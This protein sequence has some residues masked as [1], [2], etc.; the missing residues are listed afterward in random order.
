M[1]SECRSGSCVGRCENETARECEN[2]G[3]C[4]GGVC[5][6]HCQ[7][8]CCETAN[9]TGG[10]ICRI[11]AV[12]S[13]TVWACGPANLGAK[14][15]A[16]TCGSNPE[17]KNENCV[18]ASLTGNKR[19]TPPCC[20]TADCRAFGAAFANTVCAYGQSGGDRIKWCLPPVLNLGFCEGGDAGC[21]KN[22][23]CDGGAC[24]GGLGQSC[25]ATTD[26]VSRYCDG[27]LPRKCRAAC[28]TDADC[29]SNE[30][31]QPSPVGEPVLRCVPKP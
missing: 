21:E 28:C 5:N 7:D 23:D 15:I 8:S 6:L 11:S 16:Q 9:C 22:A 24:V 30:A 31:C 14:D 17:C 26:C 1:S 10:T 13:H 18:P 2:T 4:D 3:Q 19:C 29:Q 20:S 12:D 27:E 25:A